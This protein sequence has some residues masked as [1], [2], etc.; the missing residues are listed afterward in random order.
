MRWEGVAELDDRRLATENAVPG[1][2]VYDE[3]LLPIGG[4]E[5]RTWD[6]SRSKLAAYLLK[7]GQIWPFG[8]T[9]KVLY[10]GAANGTTPSHIA[11]VV[12][13]GTLVAV[14]FSPRSFRDLVAISTKRE[15]LVPVL[16]DAWQ[17]NAFAPLAGAPEILYQ[18]IAQRNQAR[19]LARNIETFQPATVFFMIKPRSIDVARPPY[20]VAREAAE[21]VAQA[22]GYRIVDLVDLAPF[23]R[24]HGC[25]VFARDAAGG[26]R[27]RHEPPAAR[28]EGDRRGRP[29]G[30]WR[31]ERGAGRGGGRHFEG[32]PHS[33]ERRFE[34]G[35]SDRPY[36][37]AGR[38]GGSGDRGGERRGGGRPD[39]GGGRE[40]RFRR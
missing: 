10:L 7:G 13:D 24:D 25:A 28:H 33:G 26:R 40:R 19:I 23:Q 35:R 30:S 8:A 6:P 1:E 21:E 34:R 27:E 5:F 29:E 18:D 3:D 32:R 16:A 2:R 11:D 9:S 20:D 17:P 37:G 38:P 15:N 4:R 36:R 22:T 31:Q 12:R 39:R 14:E